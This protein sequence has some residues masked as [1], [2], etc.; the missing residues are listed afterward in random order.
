MAKHIEN[1]GGKV[2]YFSLENPLTLGAF[3]ENPENLFSYIP[4]ISGTS[5]FVLIDEIQY[6]DNPSRFLKYLHDEYVEQIKLIVSGSSAFYIDK[7]FSDSLA[8]RKRII[9]LFPFSFPEFLTA[10]SEYALSNALNEYTAG[11]KMEKKHFS[12]PESD[13]LHHYLNE[14]M[15]Y[16]GYP[17]VVT[18]P[19]PE[20]KLFTLRDLHESFL[21]KDLQDAGVSEEFK[22]YQL[23]KILAGSTGSLFN[24]AE[25]ANT[26]SLSGDTVRSYLH[27]LE[28]AFI[29]TRVSPFHRNVRKELTKM[30]KIYFLDSGL[31]NTI[32][33]NFDPPAER[34]DKGE[35]LEN[36]VFTFLR[37]P[38]KS[39]IHFWR[40]QDRNEVDFI[41]D[42]R[43]ALEVKWQKS[44]FNSKKYSAFMET[45]PEIPFHL[46][47]RKDKAVLDPLDL[48]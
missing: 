20:E 12:I 36:L 24:A 25:A 37:Y 23:L 44:A 6:L 11:N 43:L 27:I 14:Y 22:F 28:K 46:L 5:R 41:I 26:L 2:D 48:L 21:K 10:R 34:F 40:T 3:N 17:G 45:Y 8:G 35:L 16:G 32:L 31:R 39:R 19:D 18:E 47:V 33:E 13:Q 15:T 29:I 1:N 38:G 42:S 7:K 30:P 4:P 9:E